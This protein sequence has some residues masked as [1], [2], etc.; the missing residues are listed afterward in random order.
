[1]SS[2]TLLTSKARSLL[3]TPQQ[4]Q[5]TYLTPPAHTSLVARHLVAP[6]K[7]ALF[8]DSYPH[9]NTGI[10]MPTSP[11]NVIITP[12][13]DI[14]RYLET[15]YN[16]LLHTQAHQHGA[17]LHEA[18]Y[19]TTKAISYLHWEK[20]WVVPI[21]IIDPK[22]TKIREEYPSELPKLESQNLLHLCDK[23]LAEHSNGFELHSA[24]GR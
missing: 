17:M 22:L 15:I 13:C 12:D 24:C 5:A 16:I 8:D 1:M 21:W 23:D 20:E 4:N 14:P 7:E 2:S 9:S 6:A 3:C 10:V 11:I 18:D 19:A